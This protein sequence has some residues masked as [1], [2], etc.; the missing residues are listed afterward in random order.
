MTQSPPTPPARALRLLERILPADVRDALTGDLIETFARTA[1][2][3]GVRAARRRFWGEALGA[4]WQCGAW[5]TALR[6]RNG[7]TPGVGL[8]DD[9]RYA[10]RVLRRAPAFAALCVVTLALAIGPTTAIVSVVDPVL[11]R[12]LPYADPSRLAFI[13]ERD[14][15]GRPVTTGYSTIEDIRANATALASVAAVG[16]WQTILSDPADPARLTGSRVSWNY[17]RTLGV[18]PALGRDFTTDD[19]RPGHTHVVVLTHGFWAGRYGSSPRVIGSTLSLDGNPYTV[20]GVLPKGYDDLIAHEAEV[21][22]PLGYVV[23]QPWACRTCR[24]LTAVAR[25]RDDVPFARAQ[26]QLNQLSA[27]LVRAHP[28]D[29]PAIG[30][31]LKPM[32]QDATSASRPALLAILGAA[33][34]VLLIALANI[35]NLQLA[36]GMRRDDEFA[37][38]IALGARPARLTQQLLAEG[39]VIAT[40]GGALGIALGAAVLPV[41]IA[42]LPRT[43]PRLDAVHLDVPVLGFV[44]LIVIA[45]AIVT[46]LVPARGARR[47]AVDAAALR[48]GARLTAKAGTATRSALVIGEIA[49]ALLL[50]VSAGLLARSL[51][52][53]LAVDPG[54]DPAN[55]I[56]MRVVSSGPSYRTDAATLDYRRRAIAA[57]REIS[58]VLDAATSTSLP[59]SGDLD[60][61]GITA[62]DKPLP[63][64]ALAPYA[65]GYRV[66]GDFVRTMRIRVLAGRDLTPQDARDSA[67]PVALVSDA[68]ARSIWGG[69]S[70][71]GKLIHVPNAR[72]QWTDVVGVVGDVRHASL[73]ADDG[74]ALYLPEAAWGWAND[75]AA[76]VVR[77]HANA[78]ALVRAVHAAV[79]SI[80]PSQPVTDLRTMDAVVS[81]STAQRQLALAL[82]G[83]FALL[84]MAL[85]AAGIYGVLAGSVAART[86][87]IGLRGALGATPGDMLLLVVGHGLRLA[88]IGVAIGLAGA[89]ASTRLLRALLFGVG[90][91]DPWMLG[92]AAAGLFV[93]AAVA[94][95]VPAWRAVRVDPVTALRE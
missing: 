71:V 65:T 17:F 67:A 74:R 81:R 7:L 93:I 20:I 11:F 2:T 42:R 52:N 51:T 36:R 86:R 37:V 32:Q 80:D 72:A 85:A 9:L 45:V 31:F 58:G 63:N 47:R 1:E 84:A 13:W 54:F 26:A 23:T 82:F 44:A 41:L 6:N 68:L 8:T 5:R 22:S 89:L 49:L 79:A 3:R 35:A 95:A 56:T 92:G 69:E 91:T 18:A 40:A 50:L 70:P 28:T 33:I 57:V 94:C 66:N 30:M 15:T 46:G 27:Q 48:G 55:V 43:I 12:P 25:V 24:H 75:E 21:F 53:L 59:L 73:D 61:Y 60:R 19:D 83:S 77:T 10:V 39:L 64:P 62:Q 14:E 29:Y 16:S 4:A 78:P 88:G 34:L 87:E 38:R 90:P 76:L